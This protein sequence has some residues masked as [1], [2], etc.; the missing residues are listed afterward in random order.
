MRDSAEVCASAW[1][2]STCMAV[3]ASDDGPSV[4]PLPLSPPRSPLWFSDPDPSPPWPSSGARAWMRWL[5]RVACGSLDSSAPTS[6]EMRCAS[7]CT[8]RSASC[9][10]SRAA[11]APAG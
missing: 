7:H 1:G 11:A 5:R 3:C 6:A 9:Q 8:A 2:P 4:D 10:V